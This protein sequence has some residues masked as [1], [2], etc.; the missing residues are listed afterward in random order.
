[1]TLF[2]YRLMG[3]AVLDRG[4]FENVEADAGLTWQA[5][6]VGPPRA[7]GFP[8]PLFDMAWRVEPLDASVHH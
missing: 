4:S 2:F 1:M 8:G 5:A 3:A 7:E 6:A